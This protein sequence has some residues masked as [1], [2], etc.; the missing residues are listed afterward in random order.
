[1]KNDWPT[2]KAT[3]VQAPGGLTAA[4]P[5]TL[6][7]K[8]RVLDSTDVDESEQFPLPLR[9]RF[10]RVTGDRLA[11]S[12]GCVIADFGQARLIDRLNAAITAIGR[13]MLN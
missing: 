9:A 10:V 3:P 11:M 12:W 7:F 4:L 8:G 1:M 2:P 13:R 5:P 6:R